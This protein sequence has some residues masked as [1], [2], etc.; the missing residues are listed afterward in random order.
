MITREW[1]MKQIALKW[2]QYIDLESE[3]L[4]LQRDYWRE[5]KQLHPQGFEMDEAVS[6]VH[7]DYQKTMY[8]LK[9][10]FEIN[11]IEL[12]TILRNAEQEGE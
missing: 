3:S 2:K 9:Q 6:R 7:Q 12:R 8:P 10:M 11:Y 5:H 1:A 4:Q